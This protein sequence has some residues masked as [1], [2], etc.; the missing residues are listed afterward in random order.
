MDRTRVS[1]VECLAVGFTA[2]GLFGTAGLALAMGAATLLVRSDVDPRK[3]FDLD[4]TL[5]VIA[6]LAATIVGTVAWRWIVDRTDSS[7]RRGALAGLVVGCA[8][9]PIHWLLCV[10]YAVALQPAAGRSIGEKI[11]TLAFLAVV[12][13]TI[14]LFLF[15]WITVP[16]GAM[17][18]YLAGR[19]HTTSRYA[20]AAKKDKGLSEF[21]DV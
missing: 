19:L 4:P 5:I 3:A 12:A 6:A 14:S 9:H 2:F 10:A 1:W 8:S 11:S 17:L 13:T 7:P 21:R 20:C 18:G 16:L 15:G